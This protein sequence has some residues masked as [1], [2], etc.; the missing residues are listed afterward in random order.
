MRLIAIDEA[1]LQAIEA[2][3]ESFAAHYQARLEANAELLREA[4]QQTLALIEASPRSM[5]WGGYLAIDAETAVVV[6]T[7][8]FKQAPTPD[9][10]VE[11]A[12]FTFPPFEGRGYGTRMANQL[13]SIAVS[14]PEIRRVIAH[15]LPERN[16]S[17]R[18]LEKVGM[19]WVGE[20]IDPEDG[21][22][23]QWELES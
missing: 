10:T 7:C 12:Y 16:A 1:V 20:V 21:A 15:T 22:V 5:P 14:S 3:C 17:T 6:G 9:G 23:W 19:R 11:I 18:I 4:V 8:A 13:I 2:G